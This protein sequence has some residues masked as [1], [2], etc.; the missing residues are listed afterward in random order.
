MKVEM[1]RKFS[2]VF[3]LSLVHTSIEYDVNDAISMFVFGKYKYSQLVC[4][5]PF[6]YVWFCIHISVCVYI[7]VCMHWTQLSRQTSG[8][9]EKKSEEMLKNQQQC[10]PYMLQ[11]NIT[12]YLHVFMQRRNDVTKFYQIVLRMFILKIIFFLFGHGLQRKMTRIK[13]SKIK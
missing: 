9:L 3:W 11:V 5:S 10:N 13:N 4:I 8:R 6:V 2:G 12:N 7:C 1:H